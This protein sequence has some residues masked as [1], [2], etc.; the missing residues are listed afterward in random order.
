MSQRCGTQVGAWLILWPMNPSREHPIPLYFQLKTMLLEDILSG[1]Y[2]AGSR[3][4]TEHELCLRYGMSRTPVTRALTELAEEG[5][6]VRH[7]RRGT[8]VNPHWVHRNVEGQELRVM[9][10]DGPWEQQIRR[11]AGADVRL[12]VLQ[13]GLHELHSA[14]T[15]AVAAGLGPD[16]VVLDSVWVH[17]FVTDDFLLPLEELDP[18]WIRGEYRDDFLHPFVEANTHHGAT[19]AVQAEADVAG[20]WYRR[21]ALEGLGLSEP[22][23][24]ADLRRVGR[25]LRDREGGYPLVLPGGSA[26]GEA[27]TYCLLAWLASNRATVLHKGRVTLNSA[28]SVA[29]L[30]FL[31]GLADDA[32]VPVDVVTYEWDRPI[33]MLARGE[34]VI[35]F[36]GSY[37]ARRLAE[38]A[39]VRVGDVTHHFNFVPM[40]AGPGGARASL[41]GGMV[42]CLT[43][44][45]RNPAAAMELLKR[46]VASPAL[47]AMHS[48]T[49]QIPPRLSAVQVL[50]GQSPFLALTVDMLAHA[51]TRP[52]TSSY[53]LVSAQLQAMLEGMF[54][55]LRSPQAAVARAAE[56]ISAITGLP[57][58][59]S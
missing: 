14:V 39:A 7:R 51:A 10:P 54:T 59:G 29:A 18:S 48:E 43:R 53:A 9:V 8:F 24:W 16:L 35:S 38:A 26:A 42:Y 58:A 2:G 46:L 1:G 52:P 36:G 3:L 41:A 27:T 34:A 33:R 28:A 13:V 17:E 11:A 19:Y 5:V 50:A 55:R 37:E 22:T 57:I 15:R 6:V 45:A 47:R 40:P 32:I 49:G 20:V 23:T 21:A 4:P 44:Q 30:R 12:S 25:E 56:M 31:R